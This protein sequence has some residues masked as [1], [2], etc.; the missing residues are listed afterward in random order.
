MPFAHCFKAG[1]RFFTYYWMMSFKNVKNRQ[2]DYW[3]R[4]DFS[5][6]LQVIKAMVT[7]LRHLNNGLPMEGVA[8]SLFP[9]IPLPGP[10]VA[11][12]YLLVRNSFGHN[13]P[14]PSIEKEQKE[15]IQNIALVHIFTITIITSLPGA[16]VNVDF[17]EVVKRIEVE[18]TPDC[19]IQVETLPFDRRYFLTLYRNICYI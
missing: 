3:R 9:G 12:C 7:G 15:N 5:S 8:P 10:E 19:F 2:C 1:T 17:A 6:R 4:I 16:V 11:D 18:V 14:W 13:A